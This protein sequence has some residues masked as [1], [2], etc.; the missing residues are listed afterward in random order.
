MACLVSWLCKD[1]RLPTCL[2]LSL[3]VVSKKCDSV[4]S[5]FSYGKDSTSAFLSMS[6][7]KLNDSSHLWPAMFALRLNQLTPITSTD[8][9]Q[10]RKGK[11]KSTDLRDLGSSV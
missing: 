10:Y 4:S 1:S 8:H 6:I 5:T 2:Q 3:T 11:S 9:A 7:F